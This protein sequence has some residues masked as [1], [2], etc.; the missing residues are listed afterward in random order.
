[1]KKIK[2]EKA[3]G[4]ILAHDI[5][6]IIPGKFKGVAFK[7]G[8]VITGEDLPE[9]LRLGKRYLYVLE[10]RQ[11][12][13][14]E[15]EAALRIA[16]AVSGPNLRWTEPAEGKSNIISLVTGLLK[17]NVEGLLRINKLEN[18]IISTLKTNF[19]CQ[20]DQVVAATR[21]IPLMISQ[22][23][24][25]KV[26]S[27]ARRFGPIL[28]V[29]PYRRLRF[30]GVVTGS[31]IYQGLIKDEFDQYVAQKALDYGCQYLKKIIV[32]DD[33]AAISRA[34]LELKELGC[35]LILTTGGLS[36]DPDDVTRKGIRKAGARIISYGS[37]VLPGAMFL[38]ARLGEIPILGLP[39]CVYYYDTTVYDLFLP[40]VL[41]GEEITKNDIAETGHGGL[42]LNCSNCRYPVCP[43]GK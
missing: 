25:E 13:L 40:R 29:L 17:V 33:A 38:Y 39:A 20:K 7:K 41:A 2:A 35:D 22:K 10:L 28:Q 42:C 11:D 36:V 6:R 8:H 43:F 27:L 3:V 4:T 24:I 37:P 14:H 30:G 32:P 26:E 31:E 5:T 1:M 15:N 23:K 12:Q 34:V 9:L 18:I 19:P 16:P 21:I